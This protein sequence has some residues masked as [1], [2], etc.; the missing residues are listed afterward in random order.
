MTEQATPSPEGQ[1]PTDVPS[2]P[3]QTVPPEPQQAASPQA[4]PP[5]GQ[6]APPPETPPAEPQGA[7]ERVVP[8]ADG[9]VLPEG[10]PQNLGAMANKLGYTQEQLDGTLAEFANV[11]AANAAATKA[12]IMEQGK[13]LVAEWG[14]QGKTNLNLAKRAL[15]QFDKAGTLKAALN[16]SGYANH[17]AVL[18]FLRDLGAGLQEGG[19]LKGQV[20]TPPP[21]QSMAHRMYPNDK[22]KI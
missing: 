15:T 3:R 7:P 6:Q 14:D 16:E 1:A 9:Y 19:F 21:R 18:T 17:P 10:V 11:T 12:A 20:H 13:A 5:T 22:P 4:T 2:E 8:A